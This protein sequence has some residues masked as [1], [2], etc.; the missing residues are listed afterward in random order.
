MEGL[1]GIRVMEH[2]SARDEVLTLDGVSLESGVLH[3]EV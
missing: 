1:D 3:Q 2:L